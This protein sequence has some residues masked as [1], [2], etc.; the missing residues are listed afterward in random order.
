VHTKVIFKSFVT[1]EKLF[2]DQG[3]VIS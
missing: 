1:Y 2:I 3:V